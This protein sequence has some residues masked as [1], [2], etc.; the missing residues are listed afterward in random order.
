VKRLVRLAILSDI[1]GHLPALEAAMSDAARQEVAAIVVA[2]DLLTGGPFPAETLRLLRSAGCYLIRGNAEDYLAP[3]QSGEP[4]V[5][6][7]PR[8]QWAVAR[9][10]H[11]QLDVQALAF[12][13][14]LPEQL[15]VDLPGTAPIR[16]VHGS[17]R[18]STESVFPDRDLN[19]LRRFRHQ[20]LLRPA[21]GRRALR[22]VLAA[23]DEA[24]LVCGHTHVPWAQHEDGRLAL[25]PGAVGGSL[26]EDAYAWYALL[27]W[28]GGRWEVEHRPVAY[29]LAGLCA[30][31]ERSGLLAAGGPMA[32]AFMLNAETG[33]NVAWWLV[34]HAYEL[35]AQ[36]GCSEGDDV[37][38][39]IWERAAAT[40]DWKAAAAGCWPPGA[41]R[42]RNHRA[43]Q[44]YT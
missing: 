19:L 10:T 15:V 28:R 14:A 16:V 32:R 21:H 22:E 2:G 43:S 36:A 27:T 26:N 44:A 40:F 1:H 37:P 9:W 31:F 34:T 13:G 25:N 39:S 23:I 42:R 30:A 18:S 38:D 8:K 7:S 6:H 3:A 29:Y 17:P 41:W 11:A 20:G 4:G 5:C 33:Q 12:L 24:V 35:A